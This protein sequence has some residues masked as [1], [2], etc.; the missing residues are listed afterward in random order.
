M[1]AYR[2][3]G[4]SHGWQVI[5]LH[6]DLS[7]HYPVAPLL[8][9]QSA[10]AELAL[11]GEWEKLPALLALVLVR[12]TER[13]SRAHRDTVVQLTTLDTGPFAVQFSAVVGR[14]GPQVALLSGREA[15]AGLL[16]PILRRA[17]AS[18]NLRVGDHLA[19]DGVELLHTRTLTRA[20]VDLEGPLRF[21]T[22]LA[23]A[24]D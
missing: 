22:S 7:Q 8:G 14:R 4:S 6:Q 10:Q 16:D 20:D 23:I 19:A 18:E 13:P 2:G 5:G 24:L 15:D 11:G 21:L 9:A 1:A 17:A 12:H 3:F